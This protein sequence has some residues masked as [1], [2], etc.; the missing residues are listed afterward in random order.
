M[1]KSGERLDYARLCVLMK[2]SSHFPD[3]VKL[4]LSKGD[5][6]E[7]KIEYE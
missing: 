4:K 7:V 1:T 3:L 6:C 5:V 2:A